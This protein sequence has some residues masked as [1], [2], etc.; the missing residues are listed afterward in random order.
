MTE[1]P[2]RNLPSVNDVLEAP[3]A[4]ELEGRHAHD[5]I[6]A[7]VRE[8]LT[9]LRR[10]LAEGSPVDGAADAVAVAERVAARLERELQ[11]KL[12]PVIN[13]TGIVLHT[14]LGRSPVAE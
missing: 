1:N 2:F 3:Q 12:R 9:E 10:Q 11:P 13:G 6:V 7:T 5:L 4:R 8:E 14:N